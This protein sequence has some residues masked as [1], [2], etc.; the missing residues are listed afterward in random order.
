MVNGQPVEEKMYAV[1]E[2]F[3]Q[4]FHDNYLW[5][6]CVRRHSYE[7]KCSCYGEAMDDYHKLKKAGK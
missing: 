6:E 4:M 5:L 1:P 3:I 7:A 2:S